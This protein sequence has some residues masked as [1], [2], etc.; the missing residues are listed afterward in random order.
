M[1]ISAY[2]STI[3]ESAS[4]KQIEARVFARI[5]GS[6]DQHRPNWLAARDKFSRMAVLSHG[7]R[8]A[9]SQNR[10]LWRRLRSDLADDSNA[11]PPALRANL[12]S[13]SLWV[14][15]TCEEVIG[16]GEG[17]PALIDVNQNILGGLTGTRP[18]PAAVEHH[19]TQSHAQAV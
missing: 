6:M 1:S 5:T 13:I 16:G 19:G 11:L 15:R 9:V 8:D 12:I 2:K 17:L 10:E 14:D 4:P 18:A 7:L 3:R